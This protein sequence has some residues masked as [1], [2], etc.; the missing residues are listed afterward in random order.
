[1]LSRSIVV[2]LVLTLSSLAVAQKAGQNGAKAA[3]D[4]P[5]TSTCAV[6]YSSGSGHNATQYCVTVNGN[7][8]QFSRGGDEYIQSGGIREG[9]GLCDFG[10]GV[11][12]P[13]FDYA[14][15]ASGWG[16][17]TFSNTPTQAVSTRI[18]TDGLW[19]IT[20]TITKVN[21]TGSGPGSAKVSMKIKNL[22]GINRGIN[23]VRFGDV[24]FRRGG[25][26]TFNNDFDFT[27]DTAMNV[28]PGFASGLSLVNGTFSF[29][30]DAFAQN[31]FTGPN[32]CSPGAALAPQPFFGD[33]SV[34]Q[35]YVLTVPKLSTKTFNMT[36]K[37]I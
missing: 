12:V 33:G 8:A 17:A 23:V 36:Y 11:G 6:T 10:S 19:Q 31:T 32:P 34:V 25:V 26:D 1:M 14:D 20:N 5:D 29:A 3:K 15:V 9:Y 18:S 16:A 13:Y 35:L 2:A 30:Y 7:I 22:T 4:A 24:D 28:E 37:P 21:A 27:L